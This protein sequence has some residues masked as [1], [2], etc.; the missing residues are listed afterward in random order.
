[1]FGRFY[2]SRHVIVIGNT[3]KHLARNGLDEIEITDLTEQIRPRIARHE[4]LFGKRIRHPDIMHF[5]RNVS[6]SRIVKTQSFV[7]NSCNDSLVITLDEEKYR[8]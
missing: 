3:K 2:K 8:S 1:M 6:S 5:S 4:G 7:D